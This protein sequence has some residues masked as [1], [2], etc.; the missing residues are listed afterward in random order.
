MRYAQR[1]LIDGKLVAP[2][3][4]PHGKVETYAE[5]GCRCP[6]CARAAEAASP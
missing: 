2:G 1:E 6:R 5:H 3:A 4:V